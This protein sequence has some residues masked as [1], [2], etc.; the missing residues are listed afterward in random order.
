MDGNAS[1]MGGGGKRASTARRAPV[2]QQSL[3]SGGVVPGRSRM[4]THLSSVSFW[5]PQYPGGSS[6]I[7]HAPFAFWITSVLRPRTFVEL[8]THG[9]Y[10]FFAFCQAVKAFELE[11]RCY[12]VDTWKG[13]EHAG[14]YGEEVFKRVRRHN[15]AHYAA[16]SR[17][18]RSTFDEASAHFNDASIDLLHIDGRHFYEDVKHDFE[19]WRPKLSQR[20][21]VLFHDT[22]VRERNFGVFK[23]WAELTPDFP[24]FEFLHGHGLGVLG[25]GATLPEEMAAFLAATDDPNVAT[26][27]RQAYARLGSALQADFEATEARSQ[28]STKLS[29][30][31]ARAGELEAKLQARDAELEVSKARIEKIEGTVASRDAEARD[32][33]VKFQA[34][35]ARVGKLQAKLETRDAELEAGNAR[36]RQAAEDLAAAKRRLSHAAEARAEA[37]GRA[38]AAEAKAERTRQELEGIRNSRIWRSTRPYRA[39]MDALRGRLGRTSPTRNDVLG[40]LPLTWLPRNLRRAMKLV[41]W[42]GTGQFSRAI[43]ASLPYRRFVPAR[44]KAAI[45][46][47]V[48]EAMNRRLAKELETGQLKGWT[49]D[50][51]DWIARNDTLCDDDRSLI[52]THI[53][54]F[55]DKPKFSILMPVYNT[56]V[57]YLRQGINSLLRQL[58]QN[59]ELCVVDDASTSS[60][61]REVL[62]EYAQKDARIRPDF[63]ATNGGISACSNTALEMASGDWIVLMD[64]D[65]V[66]A[67][68]ALYLVAEAI[69][70]HPDAVIIYSDEDHVDAAGRRSSPYFKPDWDYDLFLGQNLISHLGAYR[71]HLARQM[72]G[73]REGFEGSQDWDFALRILDSAPNAT[74]HH[75]PFVLYHW[76]QTNDTFSQTSL[77]RARDAAQRAVSDHLERTKQAAVALPQG[78]SSHL[79]IKRDL[80]AE[81]PLVSI[82]IPTK[83]QCDLLRTC[84]DGLVNRTD[85]DP[86]EVVVIDNGSSEGDTLAFLADVGSRHNVKVVEDP[87]PFNFSRLVNLGVAQSSGEVCVLFNNDV[88]VINSD[89]LCEMVSHALRPEVGAVGAKLYY[90]NDTIQHAGVILG[91]GG[92]AGHAHRF[93]PRQSP[94]YFNRLNLTHSLSCVTAA[95]LALRREVYDE[96]GGLNEQDLTVA[97]NDVDFCI[98][99]RQAGYRIIWTP[100]AE[101]YHYESISRGR[102]TTPEKATRAKAEVGYM[103]R[104][105]GLVLDNDPFY[106]PNLSLSSTSFEPDAV[107]RVRKPWLESV[108]DRCP[109]CAAPSA[110]RQKPLTGRVSRAMLD[111]AGPDPRQTNAINFVAVYGR[112]NSGKSTLA[113]ALSGI[114]GFLCLQADEILAFQIAPTLA[115]R[116]DFWTYQHRPQGEMDIGKYIDSESY[117]HSLFV[118]CLTEQLHYR[119]QQ[120]QTVNVVVLEGYVFKNYSH[121]FLDLG[122][123]PERTLALHAVC[124]EGRHMVEGFDVTGQ[125]YDE[126]LAHIRR[127]FRTKCLEATVSKSTYQDFDS[128]GL[129]QSGSKRTDSNTSAKYDASHLDDVVQ[130]SHRVVDI[131]CNAGYFCFRAADR[132]SGSVV[133][134]DMA[135]HWLEIAS[136]MN[137]SIFLRDNVAFLEADAFDFMAENPGS[138]EIVHCASTYHYFRDRQDEF[139]RVVHRALSQEGMFVLEVELADTGTRPEVIQ[140]SRGVDSTPCA[141]PNRAMFLEHIR[142]LFCIRAEFR[143][144]FQQGSYYDRVY[145]HLHP[146]H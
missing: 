43:S 129:G 64:H 18:V 37:E 128:L 112:P 42:L 31:E 85:Y 142:G 14:F 22:N 5:V 67:E 44:I 49:G 19:T 66:L 58:Y 34:Q 78:V 26:E 68:H 134:V 11:T 124:S 32:L 90:A 7:D 45:P 17:L 70:G 28:L 143:S 130:A 146:I 59:W 125:R 33:A 123:P 140:R 88:D 99:I 12:A 79:R 51:H 109:P 91:L 89:W 119:L 1:T 30:Q 118:R 4:E 41:W 104:R 76:R 135:R 75:I 126:V 48:R 46:E 121:I 131:G 81:R 47:R 21:V 137:N 9:G 6:W 10:S 40:S 145:F 141:F 71:A 74:V 115:N 54:S 144:V 38:R 52:R 72:G 56:P 94:G 110:G 133:G 62:E 20:A 24:A 92:V 100:N 116:S 95:C 86:I 53:A 25:Y 50:Y 82:V 80:P 97:F 2:R 138:F 83:D 84:I 16:F 114:D 27:V 102:D 61:I 69:N 105:W 57:E 96:L 108:A 107:T 103:R 65:D 35:E 98:R 117:N 29:R 55:Q 139:L 15:E 120:A 8:G 122:L 136:H 111:N 101:L 93:A 87:R 113:H 63:R 132:T 73:F 23:L 77:G 127:T 13:D 36:A 39:A 3:S 60:E 106:N